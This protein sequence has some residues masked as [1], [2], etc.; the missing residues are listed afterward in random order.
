MMMALYLD[1]TTV[2]ADVRGAQIYL[3]RRLGAI[4]EILT[5]TGSIKTK[6]M[7]PDQAEKFVKAIDAEIMKKTPEALRALMFGK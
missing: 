6:P 7:D 2:H 5:F 4:V 1:G 3:D